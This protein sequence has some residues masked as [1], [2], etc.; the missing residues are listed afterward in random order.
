MNSIIDFFKKDLPEL[1]FI[2]NLAFLILSIIMVL[3]DLYKES[4]GYHILAITSL[5]SLIFFSSNFKVYIKF[6]V[7]IYNILIALYSCFIIY[8]YCSNGSDIKYEDDDSG[9][10]LYYLSLIFFSVLYGNF[11]SG[12][13][14]LF[15]IGGKYMK[16]IIMIIIFI[17]SLLA[18]YY[19]IEFLFNFNTDFVSIISGA[20]LST[21]LAM[22]YKINDNKKTT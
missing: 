18:I 2:M 6:D 1:Y 19:T 12:L 22:V 21:I 7:C 4:V 10:I 14:E 15:L 11:L 17:L 16:I 9:S 8:V 20:F 13:F 3:L 5:C